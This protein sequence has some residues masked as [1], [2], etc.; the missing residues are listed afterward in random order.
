MPD[1]EVRRPVPS[2]DHER[3]YVPPKPPTD[4]RPPGKGY[5]PP[6]QPKSPPTTPKP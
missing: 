1:T 5:V 4:P 3:G 6:P 2:P